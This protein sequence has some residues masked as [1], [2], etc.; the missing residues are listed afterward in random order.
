MSVGRRPGPVPLKEPAGTGVSAQTLAPRP[1]VPG[2]RFLTAG[3][4]RAQDD[5]DDPGPSHGP[6]SSFEG[7]GDKA[8]PVASPGVARSVRLAAGRAAEPAARALSEAAV[9]MA[10]GL[11]QRYRLGFGGIHRPLIIVCEVAMNTGLDTSRFG[12]AAVGL[13][14]RWSARL[15]VLA[16]SVS[17]LS[18]VASARGGESSAERPNVVLIMTDNHGAWTLGC[19]GNK[20][21]KTPNIDR[22]AAEGTLFLRC[23]ANNA[24]CSPTR[25]TFLTGLMPCQHGVHRYLGGGGAQIGPR[26]YNTLEEF[27]TL[28]SLLAEAGYVCGLSGKWHLGD[29]LHP[30]EGFTFWTTMPHGHTRGFYDQQVIENGQIRIERTYLTDYWT[31]RA[32]QFI[33]ENRQRPFFLFLAYNGP[34]GLGGAMLKPI[35]NRHEAAY[36]DAL[37]PSFP[38][39]KP[40]PWNYNYGDRIGDLRAIRRYAAEISGIDD[41]VGRVMAALKDLGLERRTLVVFTADQ[42]MAGGHSGFWGMGDHTRPLTAFD[43]TMHIPL[44]FRWPGRIPAGQ[45]ADQLVS[46]V[47]FMPTMLDYLGLSWKNTSQPRSPGRSFAAVLRGQPLGD[48]DNTIFYEF[49]NV[50]AIRTDRWKYIERFRQEPDELYDLAA[51]PGEENN[52]AG[53]PEYARIQSRLAERLHAYFDR[54]A[55]PKWDLWKGGTSK[56]RLLMARLFDNPGPASP[57]PRQDRVPHKP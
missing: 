2:E 40:H 19:Y 7:L 8:T 20:D 50:R 23:F 5:F 53:R 21:I 28:P 4:G 24:V 22:L 14:G 41:G 42:G 49:E 33:R 52:V 10:T 44:I 47:D 9:P 17:A 6:L 55:D 27:D 26:A 43:W 11:S 54:V 34:Y 35:R 37:L 13:L 45:R 39:R 18:L 48:W 1:S 36:A 25:A 30:Q 29:N 16:L 31:Q 56:T 3:C 12:R 46:N 15:A 32:V 38:R 51:D 57:P